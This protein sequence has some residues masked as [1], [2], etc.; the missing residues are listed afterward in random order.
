[1]PAE[2][3]PIG[4][5]DPVESLFE[6]VSDAY[7]S[8]FNR[9]A[10]GTAR[11]GHTLQYR[12]S[13]RGVR[14]FL[15]SVAAAAKSPFR[16][17]HHELTVV[18]AIG[19]AGLPGGGNL[20]RCPDVGLRK[21]NPLFCAGN[22]ALMALFESLVHIFRIHPGEIARREPAGRAA[23]RSGS[24]VWRSAEHIHMISFYP[25][26]SSVHRRPI[27]L[28]RLSSPDPRIPILIS[29]YGACLSIHVIH[30]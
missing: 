16:G 8:E 19:A 10:I 4:Q 20:F 5:I 26:L 18:A 22:L 6:D 23:N 21:F 14:F 24:G 9:R 29:M 30:E 15:R 27:G 12:N 13:D 11:R 2:T 1:V 25:R 7:A 3:A 17:G 28:P